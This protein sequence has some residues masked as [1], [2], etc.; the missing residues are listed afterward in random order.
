MN[1]G[2]VE[3]D[4]WSDAGYARLTCESSSCI[5]AW[6]RGET[7]FCPK[8]AKLTRGVSRLVLESY[9]L[10]L[11]IRPKPIKSSR[12]EMARILADLVASG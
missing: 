7:T 9:L 10:V 5:R 11:P 12:H 8:L 3:T 1:T 6:R 4:C 2:C